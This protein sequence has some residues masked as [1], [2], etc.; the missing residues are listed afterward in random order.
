MKHIKTFEYNSSEL[1]E[2]GFYL[3]SYRSG[4][5]HPRY[6]LDPYKFYKAELTFISPIAGDNSV[7]FNLLVDN[8]I[9]E[10]LLKKIDV[11]R[12]LTPEEIEEY[13]IIKNANKYNI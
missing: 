3:I 8:E 6:L 11:V 7:V 2:G 4:H 9:F 10:T 1:K 5:R 12:E 13:K